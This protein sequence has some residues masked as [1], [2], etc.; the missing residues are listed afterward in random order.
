MQVLQSRLKYIFDFHSIRICFNHL[1]TQIEAH[2]GREES[3]IKSTTDPQLLPHEE[4]LRTNGIPLSWNGA[5]AQQLGSALGCNE[6]ISQA[7]AWNFEAAP[8]RQLS[9][10]MLLAP[11]HHFDHKSITF[12]KLVAESLESKL[13]EI[14]LF[15]E[16]ARKN[17]DLETAVETIREKNNEIEAILEHQKEVIATQTRELKDKNKRLLEISMLNAHKVREPLSRVL[18][19]MKVMELSSEEEARQLLYLLQESAGDLDMA[20]REVIG[21]ADQDIKHLKAQL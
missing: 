8:G 5:E 18:G 13:L 10:T 15:E 2:F 4:Q 11:G 7:W 3:F 20:L 1:D 21:M 14:C 17:A 9:I 12:L 6:N 19:L 16:V